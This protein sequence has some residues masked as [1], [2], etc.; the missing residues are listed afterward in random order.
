MTPDRSQQEIIGITDEHA[1]VLAGPGCGKTH[2]LARR[3]IAANAAGTSF[4]DMACLT[5]TNRAAREMN[6]RI[7][8][9]LGHK[10]QG[11]FIGNI[12]RFCIRFLF[13]NS[14]LPADSTIIDE[15]E[16]DL[17]LSEALG[18]R[19]VADRRQIIALVNHRF[20]VENDF[21]SS[22]VSHLDFTIYPNLEKAATAYSNYKRENS[23]LDFDDLLL[24]A[25][26]M[27]MRHEPHS[28]KYS[29]YHWLQVDEVQDLTPIQLKIVELI[30]AQTDSTV[31]YF[32]DEQ[33]AIFDFIGAGGPALDKLKNQCRNHIYRLKRNY[34][35]PDYLVALCNDFAVY[36]LGIDK[37][38]LPTPQNLTAATE[39]ALQIFATTE[40]SHANAV[41]ARARKLIS[42]NTDQHTAILVQTND[43]AD[44][45]S[46]LLSDHRLPHIL[47]SR[48]DLFK[49][50]AFKTI[51]AHFAVT[52]NPTRLIEWSRL[53]Y[54]AGAV[55]TLNESRALIYNLRQLAAT[56]A[57]FLSDDN[58][59][60]MSR[61]VHH[62]H[63]GE[64]VVFDT[65][66]TGLNVFED[67]VVQI[68][69]VK[70]LDGVLV[71]D[72]GFEVLIRTDRPIPTVLHDNIPNPICEIY[73]NGKPID[74]QTAFSRFAEYIGEATLCGH[75]VDYDC[76]I[77]KSNFV[78]RTSLPLPSAF[79]RPVVDTL[80][81][82][83][84]LYPLQRRHNLST[85][86]NVFNLEG[87]NSHKATDDVAATAALL[88]A[89]V[90][91]AE[92]KAFLQTEFFDRQ[93][94]RQI[95]HKFRTKYKA[96]YD[97]SRQ[98]R[99]D[100][101]PS[102][103]NTLTA[104]MEHIYKCMFGAGFIKAIKRWDDVVRLIHTAVIEPS[105]HKYFCN[106]L[107]SHVYELRTFN[108]SDLIAS[109]DVAERLMVMTVHKAKGL[110]FDNVIIYNAA[111]GWGKKL[112]RARVY[113]VAYSRAKSTLSVFYCGAPSIFI[114]SVAHHFKRIAP[115]E[116]EAMALIER[117]YKK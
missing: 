54:Q 72:G 105:V 108:E 41:A 26:D 110:E 64:L 52:D 17:W 99:H 35:S 74:P 24:M 40:L 114:T 91:I 18:L 20:Q 37:E 116:T 33:Q 73:A 94:I 43:D 39:G 14:L 34:R 95:V 106:Q 89:L 8:A 27:L 50:V 12:H 6:A 19:R 113:Y 4:D 97:H 55:K 2:I 30:T 103:A 5:F 36:H 96:I 61:L 25:C 81:A 69:A 42:D 63:H 67:D 49:Q 62:F 88:Q 87:I 29:N 90:P 75:N 68:A 10:P 115:V 65:E 78:R 109:G 9:E 102:P 104:E 46:A 1:L 70:F 85:M 45:I 111:P 47:I 51:F 84:L 38:N 13:E 44:Q 57:D 59:S 11:L 31:I 92:K 58:L 56:P 100:M 83:R 60:T 71:D 3:I 7:V 107:T 98:L 53:L 117:L 22:L 79:L 21:P 32:G 77:V 86:I 15:E 23:L 76:E 82:C 28:L 112:D 93:A 48:K 80:L 16:R 66:T 101:T